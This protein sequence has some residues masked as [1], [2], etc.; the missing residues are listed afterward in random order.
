MVVRREWRLIL[1]GCLKSGVLYRV[2]RRRIIRKVCCVPSRFGECV[3]LAM[4][5]DPTKM[6]REGAFT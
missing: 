4:S 5:Y 2:G 3:E 6:R 1:R